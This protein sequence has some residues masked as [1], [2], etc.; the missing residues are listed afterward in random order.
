MRKARTED[1]FG[2]ERLS[3]ACYSGRVRK[4]DAG[5]KKPDMQADLMRPLPRGMGEEKW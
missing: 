2:G 5:G 1:G 3:S 4:A